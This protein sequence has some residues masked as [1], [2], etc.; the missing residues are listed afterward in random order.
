MQT[1]QL[2]NVV[3]APYFAATSLEQTTLQEWTDTE[4][5]HPGPWADFETDKF[6]MTLPTSWIYSYA[7]PLTQLQDWDLAMEAVSETE[8]VV[9]DVNAQIIFTV[10]ETGGTESLTL[11]QGGRTM[12]AP[13]IE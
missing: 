10:A 7:D 12:V 2:T 11:V 5:L 4:R 6:M 9:T 8:F 13:R 1:V 3:P